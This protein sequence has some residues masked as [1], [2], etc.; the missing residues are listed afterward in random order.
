MAAS[1]PAAALDGDLPKRTLGR[2]GEKVTLLTLGGYH[3][4]QPKVTEQDSLR[5]VRSAIDAGV[6]FLDNAW[7]YYDGRSEQLMG[8]ALKDGYRDKVLLMTKSEERTIAGITKE[9]E[10]SL[11]RFDLDHVDLFQFH[12]IKEP[13]DIE[14]IYKGG[15]IEWAEKQREKGL[16]RY[17]GFTGHTSPALHAEMIRRGYD[18]DTVQMPVNVLDY[19][20][21]SSFGKL[22]IPLAKKR[23][24]GVIAMKTNGGGR[25][26]ESGAATPAQSL[27]FAM[28]QEVSTVCSGMDSLD[29]LNQNLAATMAFRPYSP[30]EV[31]A[32]LARCAPAAR[33]GRFEAYRR[34][35]YR[36]GG[37]PSAEEHLA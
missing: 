33:S 26:A 2:T 18:W 6:N 3:I 12:A 9:F 17:I 25:V 35:G 11:R 7:M 1:L 15:L 10:T 4:G 23:N 21:D 5:I 34:A 32:L 24:I 14:A 13:A 37:V 30:E 22:V 8:R 27:R 19:N 29:V 20:N 31:K 36:D 28:S 16:L